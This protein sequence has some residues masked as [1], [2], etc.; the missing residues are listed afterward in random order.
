DVTAVAATVARDESYETDGDALT[1]NR[2]SRRNALIKLLKDRRRDETGERVCHQGVA[3]AHAGREENRPH[4]DAARCRNGEL[5]P[6][7]R[8]GRLAPGNERP[9]TR[10][11]EGK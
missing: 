10:Q 7:I 9:D 2:A 4:R 3:A 1:M 11:R 6:E 8:R 5:P